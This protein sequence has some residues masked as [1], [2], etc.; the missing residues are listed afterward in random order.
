M[1]FTIG[2]RGVFRQAEYETVTIEASIT[3]DDKT[4]TVLDGLTQEEIRAFMQHEVDE[5]TAP[6]ISR[7]CTVSRFSE[8]ETVVY[9]WERMTVNGTDSTAKDSTPK[10]RVRRRQA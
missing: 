9:E 4:D 7:A 1:I 8:D 6:Q 10:R 2:Y 3:V 5:L